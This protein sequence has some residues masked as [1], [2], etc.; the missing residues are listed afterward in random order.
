M[1]SHLKERNVPREGTT[2]CVATCV[3]CLLIVSSPA[4]RAASQESEGSSSGTVTLPAGT[5]LMVKMV[6]AVDSKPANQTNAFVAPW[7]PI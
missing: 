2:F 6:D 1:F 7:K 4:L 5:R 3:I